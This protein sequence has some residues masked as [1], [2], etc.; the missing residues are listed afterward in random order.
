MKQF[1]AQYIFTS[2]GKFLKR[3]IV[4]TDNDGVVIS[5]EDTGGVLSERHSVEFHN[6]II[7]PG[8]VN[9][10]CHLELSHMKGSTERGTGL[11]NFIVQVR[12]K[13]DIGIESI[14]SHSEK[15]DNEMLTEG[16]VVC[17]DICNN[18]SSLGIK[19]RSSIKY[20]NLLEVFGIDPG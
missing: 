6:G 8:F 16:I 10:H 13:R 20:I 4:T 3:G 9:C 7:I 12:S 5:I 11:G 14:I 2:S 17:A 18:S 15:A 19:K 1:S